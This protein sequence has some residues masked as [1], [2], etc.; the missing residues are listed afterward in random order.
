MRF[1]LGDKAEQ[2]SG[3]VEVGNIYRAKGGKLTR[4]FLVAA[5]MNETAHLFGLDLAGNIVSTQS[6]STYHLE[7]REIVG[8]CPELKETEFKVEFF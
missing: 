7:N 3:N 5:V 4:F 8:R 2:L 6:Y 1:K